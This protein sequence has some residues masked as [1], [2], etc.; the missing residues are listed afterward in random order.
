MTVHPL[1]LALVSLYFLG[2]FFFSYIDVSKSFQVVVN[3]KNQINEI[4]K[5]IESI[6]V[7]NLF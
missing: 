1:L 7:P 5:K 2:W 4:E 6:N 3:I